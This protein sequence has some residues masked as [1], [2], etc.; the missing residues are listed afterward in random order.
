MTRTSDHLTVDEIYSRARLR[1]LFEIT[2]ATINTGIFQPLGHESVWLFVTEKKTADRTQ[3]ED[4]LE[5][6]VLE[7]DGQTSGR[8]DDLIIGHRNRGLEL[9]VFYR[10]EKYEFADAGF[11]YE[12][13]FEY[14]SHR[15]SEP[16]HFRL[17]RVMPRSRAEE[18]DL[19]HEVQQAA[20]AWVEARATKT[21]GQG[22]VSSPELRLA[23][24]RHA[25][26]AATDYLEDLGFVVEDTSAT[27]PYDLLAQRAGEE[28]FV[29][30]KG[31]TTT[32]E[33][34]ILTFNE[35]EH[36]RRHN[37]ESMLFILAGVEVVEGPNGP[38]ASGGTRH[39]FWP[40]DVDAGQ[41]TPI[42]YKYRVIAESQS[43]E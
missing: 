14:V 37:S 1:E 10:R 22:F 18:H 6:D 26:A 11:R 7:W 40:W 16:A 35:V 28:L 24:E 17:Q 33:E 5:G 23:V 3:Y 2:D 31:T 32:G 42:S 4:K 36:A 8:K 27:E 21:R 43:L 34:M 9:L 29:E 41:L 38:T 12:G 19:Q 39:V 15:G 30:V 25:M 20:E 13:P